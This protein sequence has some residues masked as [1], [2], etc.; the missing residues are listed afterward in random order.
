M[1][2]A[3]FLVGAKC[4]FFRLVAV[5]GFIVVLVLIAVLVAAIFVLVLGIV[6]VFVLIVVFVFHDFL[7]SFFILIFYES[8][9]SAYRNQSL[10]PSKGK[11]NST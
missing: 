8:G 7:I 5:L 4:E 11:C 2:A 1:R 6:V 9:V 3:A 10:T